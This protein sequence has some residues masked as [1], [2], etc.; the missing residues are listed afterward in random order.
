MH[1]K[2][3]LEP[4]NDANYSPEREATPSARI[5]FHGYLCASRHAGDPH[6]RAGLNGNI[7]LPDADLP[8]AFMNDALE[9]ADHLRTHFEGEEM[10]LDYGGM[11]LRATRLETSKGEIWAAL[12]RLPA[13]PMGH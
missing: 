13:E 11:R 6:Y 10:G 12:R 2:H 1:L 3:F 7:G 9:L 5:E 8:D 4:Y